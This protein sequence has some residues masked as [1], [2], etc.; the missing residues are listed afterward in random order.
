MIFDEPTEHLD[1][2]T[3]VALAS[4]LIEATVGRTVIV[5]THRPDLFH[6]ADQVLRIAGCKLVVER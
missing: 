3:A 2:P 1:E 5:L 6:G 4:D